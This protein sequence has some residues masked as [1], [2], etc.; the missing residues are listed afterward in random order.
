ME[1]AEERPP[2]EPL[3]GP[4]RR[5][6]GGRM[7]VVPLEEPSLHSPLPRRRT[8]HPRGRGREVAV[9][10]AVVLLRVIGADLVFRRPGVG[11]EQAAPLTLDDAEHGLAPVEQQVPLLQDRPEGTRPADLTG[12]DIVHRPSPVRDSTLESRP[13]RSARARDVR[14]RSGIRSDGARPRTPRTT[15]AGR[16]WASAGAARGPPPSSPGHPAS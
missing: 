4:A 12:P 7:T 5:R 10:V 6:R 11:E 13:R 2:K 1:R 3:E 9:V 8:V 16:G 14:P 15:R